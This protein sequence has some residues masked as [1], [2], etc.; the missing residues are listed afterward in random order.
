MKISIKPQYKQSREDVWND[1]FE[2]LTEDNRRLHTGRWGGRLWPVVAMA[3]SVMLVLILS[4]RFYTTEISTEMAQ[5]QRV[6]LPDKSIVMLNSESK[7]SYHP[8]WWPFSRQVNMSGEAFFIVKKGKK[9]SVETEL[10]TVL[11]LGTEF[12]VYVRD[13]RFET[14]CRTGRVKV[15]SGTNR[16]IL[17]P[18]QQGR[19]TK[20]GFELENLGSNNQPTS[21]IKGQF[22]FD[23]RPLPEVIREVERQYNIRVNIPA[24]SNYIYTGNF[25]REK[26]PG[27]VLHIVGAPFGLKLSYANR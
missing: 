7:L 17:N 27:E 2:H 3:A 23:K 9:F 19:F 20:T 1:M 13:K 4:A 12:N 10:G 14:F 16:I 25:S 26:T 24:D 21:W 22:S 8:F 15:T 5:H 6:V 11:V 18:Q